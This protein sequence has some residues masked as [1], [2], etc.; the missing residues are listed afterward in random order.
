MKGKTHTKNKDIFKAEN[1]PIDE[2]ITS[3]ITRLNKR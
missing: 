3:N 1:K 2:K